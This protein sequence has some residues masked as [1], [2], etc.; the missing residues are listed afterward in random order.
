MNKIKGI[1]FQ[2]AKELML[3]SNTENSTAYPLKKKQNSIID[4]L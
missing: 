3:Y 1:Q 4:I 2:A